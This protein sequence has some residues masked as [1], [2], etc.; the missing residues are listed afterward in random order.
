MMSQIWSIVKHILKNTPSPGRGSAL[1]AP[2]DG[3]PGVMA[4]LQ[5]THTLTD[6]LHIEQTMPE[7]VASDQIS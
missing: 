1:G 2:P 4:Q 7:S 5:P 3:A 6:T